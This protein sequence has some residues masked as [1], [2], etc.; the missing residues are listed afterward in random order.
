MQTAT[1]LVSE[2]LNQEAPQQMQVPS[3]SRF[4]GATLI[5]AGTTFGAGMLALPMTSGKAG[6]LNNWLLCGFSPV[7][8]HSLLWK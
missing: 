2:S 1:R 6:F 4:I 5:V 3:K 8:Q 7:L